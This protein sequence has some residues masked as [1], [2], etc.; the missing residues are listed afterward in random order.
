MADPYIR[1]LAREALAQSAVN[2]AGAFSRSI[3][4]AQQL[5]RPG[6]QMQQ[7]AEP[8]LR[9][10]YPEI[11][12]GLAGLMGMAPDELAGSVLDPNTARARAGAEI[13]F[14]LGTALQVAPM[15]GPAARA[16]GAGAKE[17][18]PTA[19][20]MGEGYLQR[21]GLMPSIVPK[22]DETFAG[23]AT[24]EQYATA[25]FQSS[26]DAERWPEAWQRTGAV[27]PEEIL[28]KK[29]IT[30]P[31]PTQRDK[32]LY[33]LESRFSGY[34]DASKARQFLENDMLKATKKEKDLLRK[35]YDASGKFIAREEVPVQQAMQEFEQGLTN[36]MATR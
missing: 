35:Y 13:G 3:L 5:Q 18:G 2:P 12:G 34:M 30:Q 28:Q 20:N 9:Q 31:P 11:Y 6:Q 10:Q 22:I 32:D 7:P 14:P 36:F 19:V 24:P 25:R 16:V 33:L 1:Q 21:Q 4:G 23:F 8:Y 29:G 17:L 26:M 27:T 15:V